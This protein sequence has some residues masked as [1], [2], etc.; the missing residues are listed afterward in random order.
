MR[1]FKSRLFG[2]MINISPLAAG[3][4]FLYNGPVTMRVGEAKF[5]GS[6]PDFKMAPKTGLVEIAIGGR[7][8]VGKSSL[9]NSLLNRKSLA[10]ISKTPGKTRLL[11][12]F[13]ILGEKGKE[14]LYFVDL[15]GYGY[16]KVPA[17]E[18]Q[19]WKNM[20]EGYIEGSPRLA[21][22]ILLIDSRR[23]LIDEEV[24]FAQYLL[25]HKRKVCPVLTKADKLSRQEGTEMVRETVKTLSPLGGDVTSPILHSSEKKIGNDLVWRWIDERIRDARK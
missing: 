24:L 19:I 20:V 1:G 25:L 18:R 2:N 9:I 23:G 15:P 17:S 10:M 8:N 22:F 16:A 14:E 21:G 12:Y 7:S 5:V 3:P 11:N 4:P 6:Y 13:V